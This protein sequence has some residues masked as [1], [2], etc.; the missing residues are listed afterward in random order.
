MDSDIGNNLNFHQEVK[1]EIMKS[2]AD[3]ISIQLFMIT[4]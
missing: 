1:S 2:H 4:I 3:V